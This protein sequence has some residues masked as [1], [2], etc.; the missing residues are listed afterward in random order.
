MKLGQIKPYLTAHLSKWTLIQVHIK[1]T[2][3]SFKKLII[4]IL[5]QFGASTLTVFV[6][7]GLNYLESNAK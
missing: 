5:L 4:F 7:V 2:Q 1:T 3:I 6:L